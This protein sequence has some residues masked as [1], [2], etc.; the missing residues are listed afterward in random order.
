MPSLGGKNDGM[1][2]DIGGATPV[3]MGGAIEGNP[4]AALLE[5]PPNGSSNPVLLDAATGAGCAMGAGGCCGDPVP[6]K[7][8]K[9]PPAGCIGGE[10]CCGRGEPILGIGCIGGET[11]CGRGEPILGI[12]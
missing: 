10:A 5:K 7:K 8:S 9:P 4:V 12:V 2:P 3:D 11:C 1:P 6:P